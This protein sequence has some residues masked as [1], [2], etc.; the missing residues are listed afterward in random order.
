LKCKIGYIDKTGKFVINP[1]NFNLAFDFSEGLAAIHN[2]EKYGFID[3]TGNFVIPPQ[4][5]NV[6]NFKH[7]LAKV[8]TY[9]GGK[10]GYIDK[11]GKYVW[12]PQ[13]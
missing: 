13:L 12:E 1:Q 2:G 10:I 8:I 7:G 4:F 6:E 3:K 11:T 9:K 5:D